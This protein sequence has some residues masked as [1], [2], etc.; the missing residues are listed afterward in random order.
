MTDSE[1]KQN[2]YKLKVVAR[3]VPRTK[4]RLVKIAQEMNLCIGMCGDGTNDALALK[5][6]D[7]GFAMGSGTDVCKEAGDIIITDD[8]FVSIA[9]AILFGRTFLNNIT[10]FLV[11]QMPI[12]I[13]LVVFSVLYPV[14]FAVPAFVAVQILVVNI[15][16]DSLNALAFGSEPAKPEYMNVPPTK[17]SSSL[18]AGKTMHKIVVAC[19]EF[20]IVFALLFTPFVQKVF[21]DNMTVN[22]SVR[23]ALIILLS[24][25]NGF[26]V[27][28]DDAHLLRGID[29][30]PVFLMITSLIMIGTV[31]IV[32]FGGQLFQVAPLTYEQWFVVFV[33][34]FLIIP[35]D[36][37]RKIVFK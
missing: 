13:M 32:N 12:N 24:A 31:C 36:L 29:K 10:K 15:V 2:L 33:L 4:L 9:D 16:M 8:N 7:V 21:G 34:A 11:F 28:V 27:R 35:L 6:A 17:K 14:L 25:F 20:A 37:I 26:N 22:I 5:R 23:F 3:A 19:I 30:N 1:I 18:F